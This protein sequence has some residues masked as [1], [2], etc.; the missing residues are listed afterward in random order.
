MARW[1]TRSRREGSILPDKRRREVLEESAVAGSQFDEVHGPIESGRLAAEASRDRRREERR[2]GR[3]RDEISRL[4]DLRAF[5]VIA[6]LRIVEGRPHEIE[7]G[8][9]A[10]PGDALAKALGE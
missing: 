2:H 5:R 4:S 6:L 8:D 9:R 7:K 1:Q 3:R 10:F